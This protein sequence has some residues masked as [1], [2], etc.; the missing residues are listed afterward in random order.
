MKDRYFKGLIV[1]E[2]MLL[3]PVNGHVG[4]MP[5]FHGTFSLLPKMRMSRHPL[6]LTFYSE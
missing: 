3:V 6:N 1:F 4:A 5:P 2:L